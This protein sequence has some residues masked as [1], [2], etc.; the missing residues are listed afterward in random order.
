MKLLVDFVY[1]FREVIVSDHLI[2]SL[3]TKREGHSDHL[4]LS[5]ATKREGHSD[6]L[7][8]SLATK[9]EGYDK[10]F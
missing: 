10:L 1:I 2:L 7:I 3:A 6:H 5:L 8:L 9:R 4:I